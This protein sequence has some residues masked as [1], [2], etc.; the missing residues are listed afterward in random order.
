[1]PRND[2]DN[3]VAVVKTHTKSGTPA[4]SRQKLQKNVL[5]VILD[6]VIGSGRNHRGT[7]TE[8]ESNY[9][10]GLKTSLERGDFGPFEKP[11]GD[12]YNNAL[13]EAYANQE[14]KQYIDT[15]KGG[16][17]KSRSKKSQRSVR[18]RHVSRRRRRT[19]RLL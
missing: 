6:K 7:Y 16:K 11:T 1:M 15:T 13:T 14:L 3:L 5:Y 4:S 17:R 9:Y 10:K 12:D 19:Q 8:I 2:F 18:D